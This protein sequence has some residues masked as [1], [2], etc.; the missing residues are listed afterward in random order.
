MS[1]VMQSVCATRP[2]ALTV[3]T[4][5]RIM[6]RHAHWRGSACAQR[7]AA[8]EFLVAVGRYVLDSRRCHLR[9]MFKSTGMMLDFQCDRSAAE[10][11][12]HRMR[13]RGDSEIVIDR[14]VHPDMPPLPCARLW[15]VR[16]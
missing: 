13:A 14:D 8:L 4:A 1:T 3:R 10:A 6:Q 11:F 2:S 7:A 5:H 16:G 12:A 9:V 15:S